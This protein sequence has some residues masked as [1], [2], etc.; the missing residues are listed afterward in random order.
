MNGNLTITGNLIAGATPTTFPDYVFKEDYDL[1]PLTDLQDFI[2]AN[3]H[4]PGVPSAETIGQTGKLDMTE[5]Q[6][7]LLEKVEELT[8]YTLAQESTISSLVDKISEMEKE[9]EPRVQ[10]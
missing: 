4:L 7:T 3:N 8:L 1:M 5:M 2:I 9:L 6:R 10:E